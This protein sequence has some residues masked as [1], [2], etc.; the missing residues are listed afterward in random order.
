MSK[1]KGK[2]RT[3]RT[4]FKPARFLPGRGIPWHGGMPPLPPSTKKI[5]SG[6]TAFEARPKPGQPAGGNQSNKRAAI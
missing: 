6:G 1:R 5:A 3:K 2:N 4:K